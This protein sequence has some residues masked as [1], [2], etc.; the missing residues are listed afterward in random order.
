MEWAS[1]IKYKGQY[2]RPWSVKIGQ[3]VSYQCQECHKGCNEPLSCHQQPDNSDSNAIYGSPTQ[4]ILV[5]LGVEPWISHL[6]DKR[7]NHLSHGAE[8]KPFENILTH[9]KPTLTYHTLSDSKITSLI[10]PRRRL[11][12]SSRKVRG[13]V[14]LFLT[15]V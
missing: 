14:L 3:H 13:G 7:I 9:E 12:P 6:L 11:P 10:W 4:F 5:Q 8:D 15:F 1:E 2:L